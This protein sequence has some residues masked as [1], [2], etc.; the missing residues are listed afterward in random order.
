ML[1]VGTHTRRM[2]DTGS[3]LYDAAIDSS[4]VCN[5]PL[6]SLGNLFKTKMQMVLF[7]QLAV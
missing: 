6:T 4:A 5:L 1:E 2:H 7:L 3:M